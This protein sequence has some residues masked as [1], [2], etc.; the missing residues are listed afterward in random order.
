MNLTFRIS[1]WFWH[2]LHQQLLKWWRIDTSQN[3]FSGVTDKTTDYSIQCMN[4]AFKNLICNWIESSQNSCNMVFLVQI[5]NKFYTDYILDS[6]L[7]DNEIIQNDRLHCI[8]VKSTL[9]RFNL[10][11]L[12]I[13]KM[14]KIMFWNNFHYF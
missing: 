9:H 10:K 14:K 11:A 12:Q 8:W 3:R 5:L 4:S 1:K 6:Y 2:L 13:F 7:F